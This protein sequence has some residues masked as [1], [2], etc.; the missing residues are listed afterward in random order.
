MTRS[1]AF[2]TQF[3]NNFILHTTKI[4]ELSYETNSKQVTKSNQLL[5]KHIAIQN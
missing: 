4:K 1:I 2:I 5:A 3:P